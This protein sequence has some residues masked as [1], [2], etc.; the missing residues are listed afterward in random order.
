MTM[1]TRTHKNADLYAAKHRSSLRV[2]NRHLWACSLLTKFVIEC[3]EL[4]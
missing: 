3:N 1:Y 2:T 4:G